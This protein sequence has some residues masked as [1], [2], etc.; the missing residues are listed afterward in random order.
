MNFDRMKTLLI[1]RALQGQLVSNLQDFDPVDC[2]NDGELPFS[3]PK[4]W[5]VVSLDNL[6]TKITDG[7]HKTPSYQQEGIPF[8]SVKNISSGKVSFDDVKYITT[9]DYKLFSKRCNPEKGDL[10]ITKVG[11]TGVP[12]IVPN[13]REFSLFV[14]VALLKLDASKVFNEYLYYVVLS[15]YFQKHVKATTRGLNKNWVIKEIKATL[16]PV[17]PLA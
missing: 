13:E 14:S 2:S 6:S 1:D 8:L 9:E 4:K 7:E 17:P 12:A 10:L 5:R 11:T 16:V 15:S 3:I